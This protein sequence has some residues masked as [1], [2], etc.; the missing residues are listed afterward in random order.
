M[1][2]IV[3]Y[4]G[5]PTTISL[6]FNAIFSLLLLLIANS[7]LRRFAP[8]FTLTPSEL[9]VTYLL[10]TLGSAMAGHDMMQILIPVMAHSFRFATPENRWQE[11]INPFLPTWLTVRDPNIL[12]G[13]YEG[14]STLYTAEH[15][16]AWAG[17][18][19]M[20]LLFIAALLVVM[21][22]TNA[23]IRRQWTE[24]EKLTYPMIQLPLAMVEPGGSLFR[25]RLLWI[26]FALAG[27]IDIVNGLGVIYP[28]LPSL[29]I[30]THSWLPPLPPPW[31]ALGW[32]PIAF[33]PFVVGLGIL[34]PLD[35][36]FSC[37]FF[38]FFW[39]AQMV[40]ASALGWDRRPNFPYINEQ[41][42]G[43]YMAI[44]LF[45]I[46]SGRNHLRQALRKAF[47]LPTTL[48][49]SREPISYR[50]AFGGLFV[51][52]AGLI[53]FSMAA[54]MSPLVAIVFFLIYWA[55]S[56]AVTRMRAEL[57]PP[58]HDLHFTGPDTIMVRTMG[59]E[60]FSRNELSMMS[61]YLWFNRAY[62]SHPMPI[63]LEGFK[64]AERQH[65]P[66]RP[67]FFAMLGA[68]VLGALC[69]FWAMLHCMYVYGGEAKIIGPSLIFG[70]EPY[71]RLDTWINQPTSLS[72]PSLIGVVVGIFT[73]FFL[74]SMRMRFTGWP[75]HPL[76]YAISAS[77]SL[78][79]VWMPLL[80]AWVVKLLL[81]RYGGLRLYRRALPFFFG[82]ILG[83][84]VI[85]SL[86]TLIGIAFNIQTYGF[87]V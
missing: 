2:E 80:I 50:A 45:A 43:G 31:S 9:I 54:G 76:G 57:G 35:L 66:Y 22:C 14:N 63:Q 49:D 39:K 83:E 38:Y 79:I 48:D 32:T 67:L 56:T 5:H 33:Y 84:F 53:V 17:P 36:L 47:G 21:L 78:S 86:W 6:F 30:R 72:Q 87:W 71:D 13:A 11:I 27:G 25:D 81:L 70:R 73:V 41:T 69:A 62:R 37:W 59:S 10:T 15:L 28:S 51:G 55:L 40:I 44:C 8:R 26:G 12:R 4:S 20:W 65:N 3:R 23:I 82:L 19:V 7:V 64:M 61:M 29:G 75:F 77:W 24:H 60:A 18:A 68:G 52:M 1:M 42:F 85:G 74:H 34:L 46:Y 16:H 58:A